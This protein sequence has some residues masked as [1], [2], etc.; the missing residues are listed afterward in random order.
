MNRASSFP[1][2][3]RASNTT[4]RKIICN[5]Y[6]S[7]SDISF[8]GVKKST[9]TRP[10]LSLLLLDKISSN[11]TELQ[12]YGQRLALQANYAIQTFVASD[13]EESDGHG[14]DDSRR[15]RRKRAMRLLLDQAGR[16]AA[17][18]RTVAD[19]VPEACMSANPCLALIRDGDEY[20][21]S[22]DE[23]PRR[24]TRKKKKASEAR[25]HDGSLSEDISVTSD[26]YSTAFSSIASD[27]S[28]SE[29]SVDSAKNA[30]LAKLRRRRK[31]FLRRRAMEHA[32][33]NETEDEE[34]ESL[35]YGGPSLGLKKKHWNVPSQ[36]LRNINDSLEV[37]YPMNKKKDL[38]ESIPEL[39]NTTN[40]ESFLNTSNDD[41]PKDSSDYFNIE[42]VNTTNEDS[43]LDATK[44]GANGANGLAPDL[45]NTFS[46]DLSLN[47]QT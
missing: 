33:G 18:L 14:S 42:V 4:R 11:A 36:E 19:E 23:R 28:S 38:R 12:C 47:I 26:A 13:S 1:K 41:S 5:P 3:E 20:S 30:R 32:A 34:E 8:A 9:V 43:F 39:L 46:T 27:G 24:R 31:Q 29:S 15:A 6:D 7:D 35:H 22:D 37:D 25:P 21:S 16:C 2:L 44:E 40:E 17:S 45:K 10:T